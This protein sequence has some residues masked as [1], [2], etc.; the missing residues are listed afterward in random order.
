MVPTLY[1]MRHAKSDWSDPGRSDRERRLAPRGVLA[2]EAMARYMAAVGVRPDVVFCSPAV[3]T[4]ETLE[5]VQ[6]GLGP[7]RV[8]IESGLYGAGPDEVLDLL[9]A[10]GGDAEAAMVVGHNPT[11]AV[12]AQWLPRRC[13]DDAEA[14]LLERIA[15]KYPTGALA[16]LAFDGS[17]ATLSPGD[18]DI[19]AFV[20]PRDLES[21]RG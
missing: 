8:A 6:A 10:E 2:A 7:A 4:R 13:G 19:V 20:A 17:W 3:R 21:R 9:R 18:A 14:P 5:L 16:T 12:L 1:L 11:M 15:Q